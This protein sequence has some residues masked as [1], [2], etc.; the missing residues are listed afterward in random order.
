MG[1]L[2]RPQESSLSPGTL[3]QSSHAL[4]RERNPNAAT[5]IL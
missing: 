2:Q 5:T 4:I 1:S 3:D